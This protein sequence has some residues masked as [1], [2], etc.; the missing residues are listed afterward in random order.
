MTTTL[1]PRNPDFVGRA[2]TLARLGDLLD[3]DQHVALALPE[4]LTANAGGV[5]MSQV[6]LEYAWRS[7]D[8]YSSVL[9]LDASGRDITVAVASLAE[10][11]GLRSQPG[12]P[13]RRA[14]AR[15]RHALSRGGPHLLILEGVDHP[16]SYPEHLPPAEHTRVILTSRRG[17]LLGVT[18]LTL[19][20][21]LEETGIAM[22]GDRPLARQLMEV[23][24]RLPLSLCMARRVL[25][26]GALS[27][28]A[29]L[30]EL[31]HGLVIWASGVNA[32]SWFEANPALARLCELALALVDDDP[33]ARA[34]AQVAG[35]LGRG[36]VPPAL[37][38]GA[39]AGLDPEADSEN[40]EAVSAAIARLVSVGFASLDSLG[41]PV[42]HDR[43][44]AWG[45]RRCGGQGA[46]AVRDAL[47][48]L[49]N[50]HDYT[51]D[52]D[53]FVAL[54]PHLYEAVRRLDVHASP[55]HMLIP[56]RLAQ[57]LRGQGVYKA[58]LRVCKRALNVCEHEAWASYLLH[59][60]GRAMLQQGHFG[61][62]RKLYRRS[63]ERAERALGADH[64]AVTEQLLAIGESYLQQGLASRAREHYELAAQAAV[65]PGVAAEARLA[66]GRAIAR[67]GQVDAA[68]EHIDRALVDLAAARGDQHPSLIRGLAEVGRL[69]ARAGDHEQAALDLSRAIALSDP[70]VGAAHPTTAA[71]RASLGQ[72]LTQLGRLDEA[73]A[74]L[75]DAREGLDN[76]LG[77]NH[78]DAACCR[79]EHGRALLALG[80]PTGWQEMQDAARVLRRQLGPDHPFV[81]AARSWLDTAKP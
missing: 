36:G 37:L 43:V 26:T 67:E 60:S 59:E 4:G 74:A 62:A 55:E 69:R 81:V 41:R 8:A 13:A 24:A 75:A 53:A 1:P 66:A 56:L 58:A 47:T 21:P 11:L 44:R 35:W 28:D 70:L 17:D 63:L 38:A 76:A 15:V 22:L 20:L 30:K 32:G 79:F 27:E 2:S 33:I 54:R 42:F 73:L 9:W 12:E 57:S 6:A 51:G 45:R 7:A 34:M 16:W 3:S 78:P 72:S 50:T 49:L 68:I 40:E 48:E 71:L 10:P 29:L 52:D 64:P 39:A 14:A 5:G 61:R 23:M 80:D 18:P 65:T 77:P 31:R 25:E 19:E 46:R